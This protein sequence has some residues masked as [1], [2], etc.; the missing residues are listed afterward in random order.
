MKYRTYIDGMRAFAVL[1]VI[2]FHAQKELFAAGYLGVDIFFV[3][4]GFLISQQIFWA[5]TKITFPFW[6]L[7]NGA[8]DAFSQHCFL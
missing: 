2:L 5:L 6:S 3:L 7:L 8:S 1:P 4:S